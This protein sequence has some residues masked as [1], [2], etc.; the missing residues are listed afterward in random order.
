MGIHTGGRSLNRGQP[1]RQQPGDQAGQ[2]IP[3]PPVARPGL[4]SG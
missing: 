1:L 2:Y 4:P 3:V